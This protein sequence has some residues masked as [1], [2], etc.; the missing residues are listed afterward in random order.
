MSEGRRR[1][2]AM[3]GAFVLLACLPGALRAQDGILGGADGE[4]VTR[5][6]IIADYEG[7]SKPLPKA[8]HS[9]RKLDL[10]W[11]PETGGDVGRGCLIFDY[12]RKD[13]D[14]SFPPDRRPFCFSLPRRDRGPR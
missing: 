2:V 3:I 10:A 12:P 5:F 7:E 9:G 14:F 1:R 6:L 13:G 4:E 11:D 8:V